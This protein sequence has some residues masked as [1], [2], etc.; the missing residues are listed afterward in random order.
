MAK[1]KCPTCNKQA[2]F[3][4]AKTDEQ[5]YCSKDKK[6]G[7][8]D[9]KSKRCIK[10]NCT[11]QPVFNKQGETKALYC[12]DH[13]DDGMIDVKSKRC[14]KDNCTKI[15]NFNKA[16]ETKALYCSDHKDDEMIDIKHKRCIKDNCT[17]H[18][19]YNKQGETK[20]L[21]CSM[22]KDDEMINVKSK[23]C[24]KDN[25]TKIPNFNKAGETKA[26]YCFD[27]KKDK[28]IDVRNKRCE[29]E[30]CT[31]RPNFNKVGETKALYCSTHKKD[32]MIDVKSKRC[33]LCNMICSKKKYDW[34]CFGCYCYTFPDKAIVRNHKTKENQ[35]MADLLKIY[36]NIVRDSRISGG[37]SKRRPDGLIQLD[38]YNIIIEIDENQHNATGY[39]CENKRTMEIFQ[40]L[41]NSPLTVIRFNPDKFAKEQSLFMTTKATG[42]LCIRNQKKYDAELAKLVEVI[43][44]HIVTRPDSEINSVLLRYD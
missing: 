5:L 12:S 31:K 32:R 41:G 19:I 7:M 14:I 15:P 10:D 4:F 27:H 28:M 44:F 29:H 43:K 39:S 30:N 21:Y 3:G 11:K 6:D 25:C 37:C 18:P 36:P 2:N 13:K 16:G 33:V 26:L 8:I 42:E 9:V 34:Y 38:D 20:A 1:G 17:K 35:I 24:I 22:H 40:D 23:R